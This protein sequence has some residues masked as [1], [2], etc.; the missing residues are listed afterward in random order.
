LRETAGVKVSDTK[1]SPESCQDEGTAD[2]SKEEKIFLSSERDEG[3]DKEADSPSPEGKMFSSPRGSDD[4][5]KVELFSP[6]EIIG[7]ASFAS[8]VEGNSKVSFSSIQ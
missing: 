6:S 7:E 1:S 2:S 5:K 4:L 8:Q 3:C